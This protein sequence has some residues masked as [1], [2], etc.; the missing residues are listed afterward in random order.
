MRRSK[1]CD[2]LIT[3]H[4]QNMTHCLP[5]P[6]R[7]AMWHI[8][9]AAQLLN[10]LCTPRSSHFV[11]PNDDSA[12]KLMKFMDSPFDVVMQEVPQNRKCFCLQHLA[13][14]CMEQLFPSCTVQ[15]SCVQLSH[16]RRLHCMMGFIMTT[17]GMQ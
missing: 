2:E 11:Q 7:V 6:Q 16:A 8:V 15:L 14:C 4:V 3:Y 9:N 12:S 13:T 1:R 17:Q 5:L 10:F